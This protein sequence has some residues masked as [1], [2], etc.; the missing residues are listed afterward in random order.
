MKGENTDS[1]QMQNLPLSTL[2]KF[3]NVNVEAICNTAL[4]G[5]PT[6]NGIVSPNQGGTT[7]GYVLLK[8]PKVIEEASI[9]IGVTQ[10][11]ERPLSK[12]KVSSNY[13]DSQAEIL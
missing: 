5:S 8:K 3:G 1:N 7:R 11:E 12:D 13:G 4:S 2:P 10:K 6:S 9:D